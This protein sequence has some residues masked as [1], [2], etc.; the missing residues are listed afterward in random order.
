MLAP[1]TLD[2][3][4]LLFAQRFERL[5]PMDL[6]EQSKPAQA[7]P[8]FANRSEIESSLSLSGIGF[9]DAED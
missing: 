6:R 8:S 1:Q 7:K 2:L 5:E 4:A 3:L 9:Q